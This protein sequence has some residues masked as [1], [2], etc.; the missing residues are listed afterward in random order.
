MF[1]FSRSIRFHV[2]LLWQDLIHQHLLSTSRCHHVWCFY[3]GDSHNCSVLE[4]L[5]STTWE[6]AHGCR[7]GEPWWKSA[8]ATEDVHVF[9]N[10]MMFF[11]NAMSRGR[12]RRYEVTW[13]CTILD[14][15]IT[16]VS[17]WS[18]SA[19]KLSVEKKNILAQWLLQEAGPLYWS[20]AQTAVQQI[21]LQCCGQHWHSQPWIT[22]V[23]VCSHKGNLH[24]LYPL[25]KDVVTLKN[26]LERWK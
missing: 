26:D 18:F 9:P 20:A 15:F 24:C 16:I 22:E 13:S 25:V 1:R 7:T 10:I 3:A 14:F 6:P 4:V 19:K 2:S 23:P 21:A 12:G 8:E 11:W 17:C 5:G